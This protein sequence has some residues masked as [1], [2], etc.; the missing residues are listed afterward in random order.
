MIAAFQSLLPVLILIALGNVLR[1]IDFLTE[2]QWRGFEK[3]CYHVFFPAIVLHTILMIDVR[4][5]PVFS[6]GVALFCSILAM[7]AVV[8]VLRPLLQKLLNVDGPAYTSVFQGAIR[9]N[10]FIGIALA[11]QLLGADGVALI[12]IA[13]LAFNPTVNLLCVSVLVR[14][15]SG[16]AITAKEFTK[17]LITNPFIWSTGLA[18][19]L[20]LL[21]VPIPKPI[22]EALDVAGS[23]ALVGG[24][25]AV[26]AGLQLK[27][28]F[29]PTMPALTATTL[30]L[31]LMPC[32][33][34]T[35]C[36]LFSVT[37]AALQIAIIATAIPAASGSYLLARQ[38]GGDAELMA[39][40]LT[41]QTFAAIVTMP[42]AY[43]LLT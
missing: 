29:K 39:E 24:L 42:A 10:T 33:A 32:I 3:V 22:A 11:D 14:H 18:V 27:R 26:G 7:G 4:D 35:F 13:I 2:E 28:L 5:L 31:L 36:V 40:I 38:M 41:L 21:A 34:A 16:R 12:A 20:S 19:V 23:G 43:A 1:R 9:W 25:I 30:R 6:L 17:T 37:G 8:T 15:A